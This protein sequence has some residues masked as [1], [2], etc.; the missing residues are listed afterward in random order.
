MM[1][2]CILASPF[3]SFFSTFFLGRFLGNSGACTL[4][5]LSIFVSFI[6]SLIAFLSVLYAN[7]FVLYRYHLEYLVNFL[8][9]PEVFYLILYPS[10]CYLLFVASPLSFIYTLP[11]ICHTIHTKDDLWVICHFLRDLC[12]F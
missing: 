1:Y 6:F 9:A 4:S 10:L 12:F 5:T 7:L 11:S 8:I 3:L 2:L